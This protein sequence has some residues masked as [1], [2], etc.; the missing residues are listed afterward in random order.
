MQS[1]SS[2]PLSVVA[3]DVGATRP[4]RLTEIHGGYARDDTL[5]RD[6][7]M[8]HSVEQLEHRLLLATQPYDWRSVAIKGDGFID[9]IVYSPAEPN[10]VYIHTDMGGAYR[11][12]DFARKW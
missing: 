8:N 5:L 10:L 3:R 2:Q 7:M 12:D 6:H 4:A 11:W 9:G 1:K